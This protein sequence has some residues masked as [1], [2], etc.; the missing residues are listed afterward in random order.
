MVYQAHV[1][2]TVNKVMPTPLRACFCHDF[3]L[4]FFEADSIIVNNL[5]IPMQGPDPVANVHAHVH[6][7]NGN[8]NTYPEPPDALTQVACDVAEQLVEM[9]RYIGS[10][11]WGSKNVSV[12]GLSVNERDDV[13]PVALAVPD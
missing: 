9:T 6:M 7:T 1:R 2:S 12:R 4:H 11:E 10:V 3:V 13:G 8:S 5:L